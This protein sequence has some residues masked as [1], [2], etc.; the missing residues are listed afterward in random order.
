ME[1]WKPWV[2]SLWRWLTSLLIECHPSN[3]SSSPLQWI[4]LSSTLPGIHHTALFLWPTAC[5]LQTAP[6]LTTSLHWHLGPATSTIMLAPASSPTLPLWIFPS[7]A[8]LSFQIYKDS[9]SYCYHFSSFHWAPGH[10]SK[11]LNMTSE[12]LIST[13]ILLYLSS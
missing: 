3:V 5:L 7:T 2:P 4:H 10:N 11:S 8:R 6:L 13:V 12:S 9:Q 1:C